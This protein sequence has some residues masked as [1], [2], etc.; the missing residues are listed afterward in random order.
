M[1]KLNKIILFLSIFIIVLLS[2]FSTVFAAEASKVEFLTGCDLSPGESKVISF[3]I[4]NTDI[5]THSYNLIA[6]KGIN[7]YDM[8]F[9]MNGVPVKKLSV[10]AG[11]TSQVELNLKINGNTL[12]NEDN[13]IIKANRDDGKEN[14]INFPILINKDYVLSVNSMLSKLD[15]LSGKSA[16]FNFSVVNNGTKA[17][18][19]IKIKPDLPYKW[20]VSQGNMDVLNL[21]PGET[22]TLMIKVDIPSSQVAGNYTTKF[23]AISNEINSSSISIPVTVKTNSNIGF[24]VIA[25]LVLITGFTIFQFKKHGRR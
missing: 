2:S 23:N 5:A 20:F 18:N 21:K 15:I 9:S 1:K 12:V 16:E 25:I 10:S 7:N 11:T 17:L 4:K 3:F 14:I 13:L 22:G 8:Y 6:V 19:N 24:W